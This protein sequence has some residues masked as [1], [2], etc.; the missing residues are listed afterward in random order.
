VCFTAPWIGVCNE[1]MRMPLTIQQ[2]T[3][4]IEWSSPPRAVALADVP[5]MHC[6]RPAVRIGARN[7]DLACKAS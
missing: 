1:A 2:R 6:A 3:T 4:S 7:I 5:F